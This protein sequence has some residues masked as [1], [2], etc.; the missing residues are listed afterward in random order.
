MTTRQQLTLLNELNIIFMAIGF[1]VD[2]RSGITVAQSQSFLQK[3]PAIQTK[4]K[5]MLVVRNFL[6][7]EISEVIL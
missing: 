7:H 2:I 4:I 6:F 5:E 1:K 3:N